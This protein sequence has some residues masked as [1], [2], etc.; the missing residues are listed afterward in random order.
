MEIK[1]AYYLRELPGKIAVVLPD[2]KTRITNCSPYRMVSESELEAL[3]AFECGSWK[4]EKV[5]DPMPDY[6]LKFYG[7]RS[8]QK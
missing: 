4:P 1:K 7:F 5:G 8:M 6:E 2:G 3:Y